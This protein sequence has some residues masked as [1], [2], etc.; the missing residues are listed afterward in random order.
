MKVKLTREQA[1][2]IATRVINASVPVGL[3]FLQAEARDYSEEDVA[4][5]FDTEGNAWFDY[6][7]GR[8]VKFNLVQEEGEYS[9]GSDKLNIEYQSWARKYST[10]SELIKSV[11]PDA[12]ISM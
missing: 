11:V 1:I 9:F 2:A 6:Y 7:H 3:G 10:L 12:E 5:S 8:M 4:G